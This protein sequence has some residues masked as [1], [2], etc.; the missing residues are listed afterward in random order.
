MRNT[1]P[2]AVI[3]LF[4][5]MCGGGCKSAGAAP[6]PIGLAGEYRDIER[7]IQRGQAELA[8]TGERIGEG[9]R[10]IAEGLAALEASIA[11]APEGG[12]RERLLAQVQGLRV[13][14]ADHQAEAERLNV[15]L[16]QERENSN[17][18]GEK[19]NEYDQSAL[20]L[21]SAKDTEIA[22]LKVENKKV[23]GQRNT[24]L[25]IVITA[26]LAIVVFIAVKV[27]RA[28]RALPF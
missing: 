22:G 10:D 1:V 28:F 17:R 9:S 4:A 15:Q 25:A 3:A 16:A 20:A 2:F 12:D 19:F 6:E 24:L 14:A 21:L 11:A 23:K 5:A 18:L 27:L 13:M 26:V 8:V 7:E